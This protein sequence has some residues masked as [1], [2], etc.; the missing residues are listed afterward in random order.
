MPKY[1][2]V[3]EKVYKNIKKDN[4]F[5]KDLTQNLN[6]LISQIRKAI[7]GTDFKL[8]FNYIDFDEQFKSQSESKFKIDLSVMP[9]FENEGEY[10]L[11]LAGFIERITDGGKPKFPP[12]SQLIPQGF[13]IS[14][15]VFPVTAVPPKEEHADMIISYFKSEDFMKTNKIPS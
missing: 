9:K 15:E 2:A 8:K 1:L 14:K 7:K 3:A 4:L 12:I 11:W 10:L 6:C 13:K 5:T